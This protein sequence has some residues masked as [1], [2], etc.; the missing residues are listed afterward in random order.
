MPNGETN[1]LYNWE[2]QGNGIDLSA[3]AA[4]LFKLPH[5]KL[6]I[7][8]IDS[9]DKQHTINTLTP[10]LQAKLF[11]NNGPFEAMVVHEPSADEEAY[12]ENYKVTQDKTRWMTPVTDAC[13]M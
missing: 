11:A 10:T 7:I 13:S 1:S 6:D 2:G 3:A 12:F 9:K 5:S 4:K 8:Y